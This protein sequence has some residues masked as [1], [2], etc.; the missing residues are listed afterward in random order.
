MVSDERLRLTRRAEG[1]R[2]L[3]EGIDDGL[4]RTAITVE[5]A[6]YEALIAAID[7]AAALKCARRCQPNV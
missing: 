2:R 1:L 5:I 4:A 7:N 3:H 6:K